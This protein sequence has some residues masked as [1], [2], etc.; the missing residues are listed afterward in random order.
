MNTGPMW[1]GGKFRPEWRMSLTRQDNLR[2]VSLHLNFKAVQQEERS[3]ASVN[4]CVDMA[5][6]NYL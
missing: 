1:V 6:E 3:V 5:F 4:L 2:M